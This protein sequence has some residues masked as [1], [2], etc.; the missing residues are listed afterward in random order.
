MQDKDLKK[1]IKGDASPEEKKSII[2]WIRKDKKHQKQFNL[3]KA[4]YVA[5]TL[6]SLNT[7]DVNESY[8]RFSSKKTKKKTYYYTA[9]VA[10]VMMP[11]LLLYFY[12]SF[13]NNDLIV[14]T[15]N[16]LKFGTRTVS[17]EHGGFKTVVLPDGSTIVLN[18]NSSISYP[19]EFT[20]SLRKVTLIG[21][22]FFD[23][24]RNINMPFIVEAEN[25]KIKVL[26]TSF[27]V[28]SYP[29]DEKIETTLVTG[30]VEVHKQ[31]IEQN[32][33]VLEPSER[34]V[35]DKKKSNIK[36]DKVDSNRIVAWQD[37][38]L[39]FD[40]T[41]LKQVVLDLN[42]KYDVEF[43]IQS[44]SLLQYKYTGEFDNLKLEEVLELLKISSP[45][46]YKY[47]ENKIMLDPE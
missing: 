15:T 22:A 19:K 34:A 45:I 33:I 23:I 38:K 9:I 35:F 10:S 31:N 40:N 43:V 20:D 47:E 7:T 8:Q 44:D 4:Q 14:N 16:Y 24:K 3:L 5:A 32:P 27:N 2:E 42:R 36:V 18:A 25:L 26:G 1:Y 12:S 39:I 21:E 28:K 29:K 37:G 13:S 11:F 17:T 41:P 30:K 6:D 46:N